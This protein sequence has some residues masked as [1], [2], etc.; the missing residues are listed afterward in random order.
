MIPRYAICKVHE[1]FDADPM[2]AKEI[3][4]VRTNDVREARMLADKF[5]NKKSGFI[6]VIYDHSKREFVK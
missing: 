6:G 4:K 3:P 5:E 1:E 2:K